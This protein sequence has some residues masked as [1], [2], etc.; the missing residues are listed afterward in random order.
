MQQ[1]ILYLISLGTVPGKTSKKTWL[2]LQFAATIFHLS[3]V[4]NLTMYQFKNNKSFLEV[5]S[6]LHEFTALV[7]EIPEAHFPSVLQYSQV[8]NFILFYVDI[9][10]R[11]KGQKGL[12]VM[13][14]KY[15]A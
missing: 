13:N 1:L 9:L 5:N 7:Y 3:H 6:Y 12:L 8:R 15:T 4:Y 2:K 10:K 14:V 11:V